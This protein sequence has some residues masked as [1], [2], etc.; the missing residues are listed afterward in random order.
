MQKYNILC[1]EYVP[2]ANKGEEAI[3]RGITDTLFP[4]GNCEIH[5]FDIEATEYRFQDGIHVYPGEWFFPVWVMREFGLGLSWVKMRDSSCSLLRHGLNRFY[6]DWVKKTPATM[7][8]TE[9]I[10]KRLMMGWPPRS[11]KERHLQ[12]LLACDFIIAGHDGGLDHWVCH[13]IRIMR[14]CFNKKYGV[15]GVQLRSHFDSKAILQVYAEEFRHAHFFYCRDTKTVEGVLQNFPF[16]V[17]ELVPDPA[18][19]MRPAPNITI[20]RLICNEGLEKFFEK[21]VVMCACCEPAPIAR[22][23]F[24]R[25]LNPQSKLRAHRE[26]FA[27]LIR[28]IAEKYDVNILFLPH[29]TGPGKALDDREVARDI[30]AIANLPSYKAKLME[31]EYGARELKGLIGC[32]SFLIAERIHAI[33]GTTGVTTPFM[34]LGSKKDVR[35]SGIVEEMLEMPEV[36][37]YLHTPD[38][39]ELIDKYDTLWAQRTDLKRR[40]EKKREELLLRLKEASEHIRCK[41][42][43]NPYI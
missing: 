23:S 22:H 21:P 19:A 6:P 37:Y 43:Y 30:L 14:E 34:C 13:I 12:Q 5:L 25:I 10:L 32:A 3:I 1:P 9:R 7:R 42:R 31:T 40:L 4:E 41:L 27:K 11:E 18:F 8:R 29:S 33:I 28:H 36:V 16:L 35:V 15:F 38:E 39:K 26:L 20:N 24:D 2:L 17:P